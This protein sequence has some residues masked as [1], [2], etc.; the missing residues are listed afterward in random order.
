MGLNRMVRASTFE[1]ADLASRVSGAKFEAARTLSEVDFLLPTL[2][3]D[4]SGKHDDFRLGKGICNRMVWVFDG[5][6]KV[7]YMCVE[8]D[9]FYRPVRELSKVGRVEKGVQGLDFIKEDIL[10][11]GLVGGHLVA[12]VGLRRDCSTGYTWEE[13]LEPCN[14]FAEG[15][16]IRIL[17]TEERDDGGGC[18]LNVLILGTQGEGDSEIVQW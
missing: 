9:V 16:T 18:S 8:G 6:D 13:D 3:V 2:G 5:E 14:R 10:G 15:D 1:A 17:Q 11:P 7:G 12:I 4:P